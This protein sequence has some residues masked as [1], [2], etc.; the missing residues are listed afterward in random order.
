MQNKAVI[1]NIRFDNLAVSEF[2]VANAILGLRLVVDI[3]DFNAGL[4]FERLVQRA[5]LNSRTSQPAF[6]KLFS[7]RKEI[8][9]SPFI[10][11]KNRIVDHENLAFSPLATVK[12]VR[13]RP[14]DAD[15]E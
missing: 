10:V 4:E 1:H 14:D 2:G 15:S 8:G 11:D 3:S 12:A 9:R 6:S 5:Y 7:M 13:Q